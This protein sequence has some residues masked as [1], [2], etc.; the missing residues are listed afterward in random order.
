MRI[1]PGATDTQM[2]Q[3]STL[4]DLK[5]NNKLELFVKNLP[6]SLLIDPKDIGYLIALYMKDEFVDHLNYARINACCGWNLDFNDFV[7]I[8]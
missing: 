7:D 6:K 4:N 1:F 5:K 8:D 3:K 2:F